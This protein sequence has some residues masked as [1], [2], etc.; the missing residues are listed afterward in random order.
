MQSPVRAR[1]QRRHQQQQSVRRQEQSQ[2]PTTAA[3]TAAAA[4]AATKT[5]PPPPP[6][7]ATATATTTAATT[8]TTTTTATTTTFAAA[9]QRIAADLAGPSDAATDA[10]EHGTTQSVRR[11]FQ[12]GTARPPARP[13]ASTTAAPAT[14]TASTTTATATASTTTATA[15]AATPSTTTT[16]AAAATAAAAAAAAE[17]TAPAGEQHAE[18]VE[19]HRLEDVAARPHR[20]RLRRRRR[21]RVG[22]RFGGRRRRRRRWIVEPDVD[23]QLVRGRLPVRDGQTG[24]ARQRARQLHDVDRGPAHVQHRGPGQA[25]DVRNGRRRVAEAHVRRAVHGRTRLRAGDAGPVGVVRLRQRR[26][27]RRRLADGVDARL[28]QIGHVVV[29]A[30]RRGRPRHQTAQEA[31]L[32]EEEDDGTGRR[33]DGRRRRR[34]RRVVAAAGRRRG[35]GAARRRAGRRVGRVADVEKG[36]SAALLQHLQQGLQGQVL[37]QRPHQ[38]AHGREALLVSHV[39]QKLPPKGP[40]G[41]TPADPLQE[42]PGRRLRVRI[43]ENQT[44]I[45]PPPTSH[46]LSFSFRPVISLCYTL[47]SL[48]LSLS[49]SLFLFLSRLLLLRVLLL[50]QDASEDSYS[51]SFCVNRFNGFNARKAE[52]SLL[53]SVSSFCSLSLHPTNYETKKKLRTKNGQNEQHTHTKKTKNGD[54]I[55]KNEQKKFPA[56]IR[57]FFLIREHR[58]L[59]SY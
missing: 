5:P 17:V 51:F 59:I 34:R 56:N 41:Q 15:T 57:F 24:D 27:R 53:M 31:Q 58:S 44:V 48:S 45:Q 4:A 8:T 38:D 43:L 28:R 39:R 32:E 25:Q 19:R 2:S 11:L 40:P 23:R 6:P 16:T 13:P 10:D 49:L 3:A 47:I 33:S 50:V 22:Q 42:Q 7:S 26:R 52:N 30:L 14:A 21:R 35:G 54:R 55:K 12:S 1:P 9:D 46:C 37:G 29:G 18:P 36:A 20:P